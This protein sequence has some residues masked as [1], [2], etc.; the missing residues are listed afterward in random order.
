MIITAHFN[1]VDGKPT[2]WDTAQE[3]SVPLNVIISQG[4]IVCAL[5]ENL[6]N[7]SRNIHNMFYESEANHFEEDGGTNTNHIIHDLNTIGG[8]LDVIDGAV[9]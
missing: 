4:N 2:L 5:P 3:N 8:I 7:A 9:A 6:I 1:L